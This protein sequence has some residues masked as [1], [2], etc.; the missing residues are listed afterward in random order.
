MNKAKV[1]LVLV[2]VMCLTTVCVVKIFAE[3]PPEKTSISVQK[4]GEEVVLYTIYRGGYDKIGPV[5]GN[6]YASAGKNQISPRGSVYYVY[7]NNPN[8][9]SSQHWLTEVRIPV[10][11]DALKAAGT[12][13]EMMDIKKLPAM[14]V[15]VAMKQEG[16]ANPSGIYDKLYS[17]IL[18]H[19]YIAAGQPREQFLTNV[20]TGNY[21]QMK[22]KIMIP[23]QKPSLD[24]N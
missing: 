21:A 20:M 24:K 23:I 14:E 16:Q 10:S 9:V 3:S 22:T 12:L 13:G 2:V 19:G 8:Q 15:A 11:E 18:K 5:I 6:L 4:I 1:W 17:W 7:L